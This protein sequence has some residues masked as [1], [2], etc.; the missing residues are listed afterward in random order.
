M[1]QPA[2]HRGPIRTLVGDED[3]LEA[4]PKRWWLL[5]GG[6]VSAVVFGFLIGF[7]RP[8]ARAARKRRRGEQ[9]D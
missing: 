7:A 9:A 6:L 8:A 2:A 5:V 1:K 3:L 4:T